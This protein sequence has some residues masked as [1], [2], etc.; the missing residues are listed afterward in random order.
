MLRCFYKIDVAARFLPLLLIFIFAGCSGVTSENAPEA[1]IVAKA[2]D[3]QLSMGQFT[4]SFISSDVVQDSGYSARKTIENWALE[5]LFYQE[6]I[7]NLASGELNIEK[8]VQEYRRSLVNYTYQSKLI[9]TTLDT[10]VTNEEIQ[11]YYDDHRENFILKQNIA[12]VNYIKVPLLAPGLEK[13]KRLIG[14]EKKKDEEMLITLCLQNAESFFMNDSTWFFVDDIV[15]EIPSLG[16]DAVRALV[17]GRTV[18]FSDEQ[19]FYYLKVRDIK[20]KNAL[21]PITFER[22]TIRKYILNN[23]QTRLINNY[24]RGLLERAKVEKTFVMF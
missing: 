10:V 19:Y 5:S 18:Q 14:S 13:I 21:S 8:R 6:A 23:R 9:E 20:I 22:N 12:K 17:P 16:D 15:K 2:G 4:E 24:K 1:R 7:D 3:E 11:A